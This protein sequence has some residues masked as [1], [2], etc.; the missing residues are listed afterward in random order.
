MLQRNTG[1]TPKLGEG[2][3]A[4]PGNQ[5][6]EAKPCKGNPTSLKRKS[7]L[8]RG[9]G[10]K[11][12]VVAFFKSIPKKSSSLKETNPEQLL[13][14][15]EDR[16]GGAD[17]TKKRDRGA[18]TCPGTQGGR[19]EPITKKISR[20]A[21]QSLNVFWGGPRDRLSPSGKKRRQHKE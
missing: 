17:T 15:K 5:S 11:K 12:A 9:L 18:E 2:E 16:E 7:A 13:E 14:R 3:G 1:G 4:T 20:K 21:P 19:G 6:L 8:A 10:K